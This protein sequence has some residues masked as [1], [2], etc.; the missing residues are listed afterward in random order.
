MHAA[1]EGIDALADALADLA[2]NIDSGRTGGNSAW[3]AH[4]GQC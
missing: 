4:G 2:G 1:D 3:L